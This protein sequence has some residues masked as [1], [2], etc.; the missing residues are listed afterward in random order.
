LRSH[1]NKSQ[2]Y[3][4]PIAFKGPGLLNE[5]GR[6]DLTTHTSISPI[7]RRFAPGIVNYKKGAL[8]SQSQVI[9]FTNCLPMVGGSLRA[10]S[11]TK[12]GRHDI[13]DILLK[14]ALR[15]QKS[16]KS[17]IAFCTGPNP[18]INKYL[19]LYIP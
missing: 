5:L 1:E 2:K 13:A 11:T 7:R 10:S 17:T 16:I 6:L 18:L 9:K 15:H 3:L 4:C 12:T 14:V 19:M 8:D